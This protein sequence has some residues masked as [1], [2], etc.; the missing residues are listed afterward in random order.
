MRNAADQ[1][2]A[3]VMQ[4]RQELLVRV[5][6]MQE[7]RLAQS[8]GEIELPP[9]RGK[10]LGPR[11]QIAKIVQPTFADCYDL[12]RRGE[13]RELLQSRVVEVGRMMWVNAGGATQALRVHPHRSRRAS[14]RASCP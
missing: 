7:D 8:N 14:S 13:R 12:R 2:R 6:L 9:E 1:A 4:D 11:R 5:A 10:L 3:I